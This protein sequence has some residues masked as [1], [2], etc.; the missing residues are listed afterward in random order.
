MASKSEQF[1]Y[2][3]EENKGTMESLPEYIRSG[4]RQ[5]KVSKV[6]WTYW[7]FASERQAVFFRRLRSS[8]P[9]THD[10]IIRMFR[11]T[12]A[13]RASDRVSQYMIREVA[14]QGDQTP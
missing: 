5:L 13:Y 6:F 12:N 14:Y 3:T 1:M 2:N 9:W 10:P 4:T 7:R 8:Q 11:F